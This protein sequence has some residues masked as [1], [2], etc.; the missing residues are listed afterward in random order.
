MRTGDGKEKVEG[1]YARALKRKREGAV[2]ERGL[3]EV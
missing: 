3:R 1:E 2:L